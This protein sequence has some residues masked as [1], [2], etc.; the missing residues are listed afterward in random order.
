MLLWHYLLLWRFIL[1]NLV[2]DILNKLRRSIGGNRKLFLS[3][4]HWLAMLIW[5]GSHWKLFTRVL[6]FFI[7]LLLHPRKSFYLLLR[8]RNFLL[9]LISGYARLSWRLRSL[10]YRFYAFRS[11]YIWSWKSVLIIQSDWVNVKLL[12]SR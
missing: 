2:L 9:I 3:L 4:Q 10:I 6:R 8:R 7:W 5:W 11:H 12:L 1:V